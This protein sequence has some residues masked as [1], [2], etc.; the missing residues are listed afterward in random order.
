ME[1]TPT[2]KRY[3][4]RVFDAA[5]LEHVRGIL[6]AHAGASR[7][8]LSYRVCEA[9]DWR[10][11]D[12]SLKDMSCRVALLRLHREGLIE[13]PAP[14]RR[15]EPLRSYARRTPQGE[16]GAW[17]E[18]PLSALGTVRLE[19]VERAS[20]ALWNELIER[21]HYLGYKPLPGA[22]LRYF[23][24]A[25]ERLVAVLGFGAAAWQSAPR[26]EWI[27]WS[28]EQ[29]QRNLGAVVNNARFLIL[30]WVR[31]PHLASKL[32]GLA[33][34]TLP[35]HWQARYGY[36]ALL[37]ETFVEAARFRATCY[38]AANWVYVGDT[39]G[40]GKLG[41]HRLGQVPVKTVWLY[42]LVAD[43]RARLCR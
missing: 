28:S 29:R 43:C 31:V 13:L 26:D 21:Y 17:L 9:L 35:A 15:F 27:G 6:R 12:G 7:Q 20:S 5:A 19:L 37:L 39:Q 3:S 4:G 23:A 32:L 33:A 2:N 8:Q 11:P 10:K 24:Y 41:D 42:P 38:Q 30:P 36:R 18:A 14:R 16:P 34:R 1:A 25:G 22:Q 40:R